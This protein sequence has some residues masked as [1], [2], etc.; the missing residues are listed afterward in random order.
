LDIGSG[1]GE[2]RGCTD[3]FQVTI[4]EM[5][6]GPPNTTYGEDIRD[7]DRAHLQR[8]DNRQRGS[9][10]DGVPFTG[11]NPAV[12]I[13]AVPSALMGSISIFLCGSHQPSEPFPAMLN[14]VA[15]YLFGTPVSHCALTVL[16]CGRNGFPTGT[17][18][19]K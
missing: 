10:C 3:P 18:C 7:G 9:D 14:H 5:I 12:L 16:P 15:A 2:I 6:G 8:L 4:D 19:R 17:S 1:Y 11:G 13:S